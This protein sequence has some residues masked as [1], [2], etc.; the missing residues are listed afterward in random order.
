[1]LLD[2][3]AGGELPHEGFVQLAPRRIVNS[4]PAGRRDLEL[5]FLQGPG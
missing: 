2:P 4:F 3:A 1:M 5:G